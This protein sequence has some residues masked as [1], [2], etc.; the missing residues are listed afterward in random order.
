VALAITLLHPNFTFCLLL[1]RFSAGMLRV[2]AGVEKV[3]GVFMSAT[4]ALQPGV[5]AFLAPLRLV[6][7][8]T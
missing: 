5:G 4:L 7:R 1:M 3:V 6:L 2:C 8:G